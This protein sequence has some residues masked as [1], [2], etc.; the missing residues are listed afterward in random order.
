MCRDVCMRTFI[1]TLLL[2]S[3]VCTMGWKVQS[4]RKIVT[5][6]YQISLCQKC[7][8]VRVYTCSV[9]VVLMCWVCGMV[10]TE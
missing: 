9:I 3:Y 2:Y 10:W 7:M 6:L 4:N 1:F 5:I 8:Y